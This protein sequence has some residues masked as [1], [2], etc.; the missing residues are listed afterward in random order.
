MKLSIIIPVYN[1]EKAIGYT[2]SDLKAKLKIDY[3]TIVI[4]DYSTDRTCIVVKE[5]AQGF[6]NVKLVTNRYKKGFANTMKTGIDIAEGEVIVPLMADSCD[7]IELIPRMYEKITEGYDI[8]NTSRY[9][10]GGER[11]GGPISK[12]FFS[13]FA[14]WLIHKVSGVP[15]T[16]LTNSFK[17]YRKKGLE[18]ISIKSKGFEISMEIV[19]KAY[20]KGYKI[21]EMPTKWQER[22]IGRSHFGIIRHGIEF[23]KWLIFGLSIPLLKIKNYLLR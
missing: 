22:T 15:V 12:A 2:L 10:K 23:I 21:T 8:I 18:D 3:E 17:A 11:L 19:L 5:I 20:L 6:K 16:D 1:E 4:D 14:S 9:I 7:E 13:R